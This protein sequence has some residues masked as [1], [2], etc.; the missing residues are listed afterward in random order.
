MPI[1]FS[2]SKEINASLERIKI[3]YPPG[4]WPVS[5]RVEQLKKLQQFIVEHFEGLQEAMVKDFKVAF[6][7]ELE[8]KTVQHEIC[9]AIDSLTEWSKPTL[10]KTGSSLAYALDTISMQ[11]QPRG[12][13]LIIA[14]WNYPV[15]L[16]IEPLIGSIAAGCSAILKSSEVA[17]E[18]SQYLFQ[19]LLPYMD[20]SCIQM[21][22]G[23]PVETQQLLS[24]P[25]WNLIFYT[26][27]AT[28]GRLVYE[29]AAKTKTL[30]PTVLELG[31]KSPVII[32]RSANLA[33]AAK[34][35]CFGKFFNAGQTCV[36]P[37]YCVLTDVTQLDPFVKEIS[38]AIKESYPVLEENFYSRIVN[39]KHHQRLQGYLQRTEG[40]VI[41]FGET[42]LNKRIFAPTIVINPPLNDST[43]SEEIFG[44]I[45]P[46][47]CCSSFED[48]LS[49]IAEKEVPLA[50]YLFTEDKAEVDLLCS[51]S[52]SGAIT[53]NDTMMHVF[54]GLLPL[55]GFGHSGHGRYKGPWSFETFSHH[56]PVMQR[57]S[58]SLMD[59][60]NSKTRQAPLTSSKV[61]LASK[62]LYSAP[63]K[64]RHF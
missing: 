18:T 29:A 42:S 3:S 32:G 1:T 40:K 17:A 7:A 61:S 54:S 44:P 6:E 62:A 12:I 9:K 52:A 27:N 31:G 60:V 64:G 28:V 10:I 14:P 21:V 35:I 47:L 33:M 20:P 39:H 15:D 51:K 63:R 41:S 50:I 25:D 26:G 13:T 30:C 16:L 55:G 23:G 4:G 36:A 56:R 11:Y 46:I 48:G 34:R 22:Q 59:F 38:K 43:M 37:D 45:L 53:I 8:L 2:T 58:S 24:W 57:S 49:F 5:K 19:N